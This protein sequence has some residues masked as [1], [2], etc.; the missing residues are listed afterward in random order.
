[1][2]INITFPGGKRVNAEYGEITI[3][4][5]QS[6]K[7]GGR[8]AAP[9]PYMYFLSSIGTCAG[10]YVLSFC[11]NRGI[12]TE[13]LSL[14]QHNEFTTGDSGKSRLSKVTVEILIPDS[15][16]EKYRDALIKVA[17]K[18]A[19]KKSIIEPPEFEIITVSPGC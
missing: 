15:F 17:D 4:T 3:E 7:N 1:M 13:G 19:V 9:E 10:I 12:P 16:P 8:G 11:Q 5:D 14:V 2:D 18:C 6:L